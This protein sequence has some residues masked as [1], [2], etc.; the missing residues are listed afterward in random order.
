MQEFIN[1]LVDNWQFVSTCGIS[2][3]S[4]ILLLIFRRGKITANLPNDVYCELTQLI[5]EAESLYGSGHG[6]EKKE[7][8]ITKFYGFHPHTDGSNLWSYLIDPFIEDILSTPQKK[9]GN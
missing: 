2:V 3:V 8:V 6:K 7:Y 5:K 4:F 1:F 9:G